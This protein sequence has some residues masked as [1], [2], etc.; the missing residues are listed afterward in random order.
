MPFSFKIKSYENIYFEGD[1]TEQNEKLTYLKTK[2]GENKLNF[3]L[4]ARVI[5]NEKNGTGPSK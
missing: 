2:I 1:A 3:T 5:K 4:T